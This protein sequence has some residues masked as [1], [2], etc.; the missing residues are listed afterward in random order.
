MSFSFVDLCMVYMYM[1]L[2]SSLFLAHA[3]QYLKSQGIA[4]MDLK[5]QNLLLSS[6]TKPLLKIGGYI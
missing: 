1:H 5:P 3:L 2:L 4:H 6:Q